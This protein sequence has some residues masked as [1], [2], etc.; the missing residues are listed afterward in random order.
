MSTVSKGIW[1]YKLY[2]L[3]LFGMLV[4]NLTCLSPECVSSLYCVD[5][6]V[7]LMLAGPVQYIVQGLSLIWIALCYSV[8]LFVAV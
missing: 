2:N 6:F 8:T 5:L 7:H 4:K 1:L 3:N